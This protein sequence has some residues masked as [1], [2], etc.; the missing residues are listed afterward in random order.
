[1]VRIKTVYSQHPNGT[2]GLCEEKKPKGNGAVSATV[3]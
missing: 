2:D 3:T 1:M